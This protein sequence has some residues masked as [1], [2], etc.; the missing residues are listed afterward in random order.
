MKSFIRV[1][2][3]I[4]TMLIENVYADAEGPGAD[5]FYNTI[6][7][8]REACAPDCQTPFKNE[9]A[10]NVSMPGQSI[11]SSDVQ[12]LLETISLDQADIWADT[13][14]EGDY[15]ADGRTRL[16]KVTLLYQEDHI[17]GYKITYSEQAW[18]TGE[19]DF[20]Y[21]IKESLKDCPEGRIVESS[22]VSLDFKTYFRDEKQLAEFVQ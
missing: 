11:L 3:A 6:K 13:I 1:V 17:I 5:S 7:A 22:F 15:V 21:N 16:D 9:D 8:Y 20:A 2:L 19:C 4:S 18:Y 14:L 10:F 12:T